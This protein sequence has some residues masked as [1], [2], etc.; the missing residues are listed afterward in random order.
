MLSDADLQHFAASTD[1]LLAVVLADGSFVAHNAAWTRL[2]GHDDAT[3]RTTRLPELTTGDAKTVLVEVLILAAGAEPG[4]A[5][6]PRLFPLRGADGHVHSCEMSLDGSADGRVRVCGRL[7]RAP[8]AISKR[9]RGDLLAQVVD[10]APFIL[11]Q[12]DRDGNFLLSEGGSLA[13]LGLVPGQ[14][15]GMSALAVYQNE[16][17]VLDGLRRGLAGEEVVS[18]SQAGGLHFANYCRP[19][20]D[21]S[22]AVIG[23]MGLA[24]DITAQVQAEAAVREQ[25]DRLEHQQQMMQVMGT[26]ILQVWDGI[27]CAP[28][29]G[30][31]DATRASAITEAV[32]SEVTRRSARVV[33]LDL[34]GLE[35]LDS[36]T[37]MHFVGI[38][39]AVRLLGARA[40]VVGIRPA[41]AQTLVELD[42][43]F[44]FEIL[45]T[46]QDALRRC[47]RAS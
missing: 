18:K 16:P 6:R 1:E 40:L 41:V 10:T 42:V 17:S 19:L 2:L 23:L 22:G 26:P 14:V 45:G 39:S 21:D 4:T 25:A 29:I 38:V 11:W 27:L 8:H 43:Q 24:L 3:L 31:V 28:V 37:A 35:H 7:L 15:V 47:L 34:T 46:L 20:R 44:R 12:I 30:A 13:K 5:E 9:S 33:I 32:L 36:Q